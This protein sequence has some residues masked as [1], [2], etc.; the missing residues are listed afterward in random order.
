MSKANKPY[1]P[2]IS[3]DQNIPEFTFKAVVAGILFGILFGAANTYLGLRSG[4]TISTSIPV[5]VM[6]VA[7]FKTFQK[8]GIKSSILE[9]N[10]SQTIGSASSSL[11]SGI[12]F[13]LPALFLWKIYPSL[14]QMTCL[15][16]F[17]GLLGV[18]F[19][20]P[21]RKFLIKE[22]HET[23]PYPE[24][25]ACAKILITSNTNPNKA[26]KIFLGLGIGAIFK[27]IF[28]LLQI[29]P[30][31]VAVTLLHKAQI[32]FSLSSALLGV[33]YILGSRIATIMVAGGLLSWL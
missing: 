24:G 32:G 19:M 27:L 12:I 31:T 16:L 28:N 33:G 20:I 14:A 17:G 7:F 9:A 11:A 6:T 1:K 29:A 15:A 4:L 21:L 3:M 5:A 30:K 25:T 2:Y 18:I 10:T 26:K 22:E 8:I 23:L 13:T